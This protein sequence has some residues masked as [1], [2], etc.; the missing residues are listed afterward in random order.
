MRRRTR[1]GLRLL[2]S[3]SLV[4][5]VAASGVAGGALERP[6]YSIGDRW[7]YVFEA[8]LNALPGMNASDLWSFTLAMAGRLEVEVTDI[9]V[10]DSDESTLESVR[11]M[12]RTSGF[13]NGTFAIRSDPPTP[14]IAVAGSFTSETVELWE[15]G[16]YLT[17]ESNGTSAYVAEVSYFIPTRIESQT[18]FHATASVISDSFFPLDIGQVACA[19]L[20]TNLTVNS[21]FTA[22]DQRTSWEDTT[23]MNSTWRREVSAHEGV[24]VEAGAFMAYRLNQS[25]GYFPGIPL[26]GSSEEGYEIA[27]FSNEVGFYVKRVTY[28]NDTKVM[29][30]RLKSYSYAA[31]GRPSSPSWL[32]IAILVSVPVTAGALVAWLFYR[33]RCRASHPG[34]GG[35]HAR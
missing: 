14:P 21:T 29:E 18:R 3:L 1:G 20:H 7:V 26:T 4:T 13:L 30:M 9:G 19:A 28:V 32:D 5:V 23:S 17:F 34:K 12:T 8:S 27:H 6:R 2:I 10:V 33:K 11:V 35:E 15:G 24:E 16:G 25:P 22:F 31:S